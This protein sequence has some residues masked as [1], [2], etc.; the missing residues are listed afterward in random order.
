MNNRYTLSRKAH[1]SQAVN[2][3]SFSR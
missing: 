2:E 3:S 1:W